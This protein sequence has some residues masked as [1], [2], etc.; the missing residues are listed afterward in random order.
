MRKVT[1]TGF[2]VTEPDRK[3]QAMDMG[4]GVWAY[5]LAARG[6]WWQSYVGVEVDGEVVWSKQ[7]ARHP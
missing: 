5:R 4:S 2:I 6:A 1:K 3:Y 7:I